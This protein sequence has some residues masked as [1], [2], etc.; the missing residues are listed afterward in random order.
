MSSSDN[1]DIE[2]ILASVV[3]YSDDAIITKTLEGIITSWNRGAEKMFGY[4]SDEV[5]GKHI[6]LLIPPGR[7]DEEPE[8]IEKIK[9]GQII[10]HYETERVRKDG[11]LLNISLVIYATKDTDGRIFGI[12]KIARDI[13]FRKKA[14][15]IQ[16]RMANIISLSDDA[17]YSK[18]LD[19][20]ISSWNKGAENIYGYRKSEI[21]GKNVSLLIPDGKTD[22]SPSLIHKV[23]NGESIQHYETQRRRKDGSLFFISLSV[24]P[25]KDQGGTTT[26]LLIVGR[27]VTLRKQAEE[28][29]AWFA[30]IVN[31]SDDAIISKTIQGII[32]SWNTGAQKIFGYLPHE[33][34]GKHISIL[35]P[36][37]RK[38]E[39]PEIIRKVTSGQPIDHYQTQRVRKDGSTVDISLTV[40][41]IKDSAGT[42][43]GISKI[44]RDISEE[45]AKE[46]EIRILN[47]ELAAFNYSVAHDLRSPL[48][49]V[50]N[51]AQ[52]LS[53]KHAS[54][55]PEDGQLMVQRIVRQAERMDALIN[56]LLAFSQSG[57]QDLHTSMV[58]MDILVKETVDDILSHQNGQPI[59]VRLGT[60]GSAFA[61]RSLLKQVWENLIGNAIKYS[62][63]KGGT[64]I[65]IGSSPVGTGV[66][67]FIRDNGV[68]FDMKYS[69]KVFE[70]FQR[71]HNRS[72]YEGS[73]VGLAIVNQIIKRHG[74]RIW[75]ESRPNEGATFYFSL[76]ETAQ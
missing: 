50:M 65:E 24:S 55:L 75:A 45:K 59:D 58:D 31:S 44:A 64:I 66:I 42:I 57:R 37:D 34:I 52:I 32:T 72:E 48:R 10:D 28:L 38:G 6:S 36:D 13:T 40:S 11:G 20:T 21:I 35:I 56:D 23:L 15:E 51:F 1:K 71:L 33:V 4:S 30:S 17:I 39:E 18:T 68:G 70:A 73:G 46:N 9:N 27:D 19:G 22:E 14:E 29:Q 2:K 7:L 47:D 67:Y 12:L 76:P 69:E 62:T 25:I 41:P 61:D 49:S 3:N 8:I 16:T 60:L 74:G 5:I 63:K 53:A 43:V 26:G 54:A